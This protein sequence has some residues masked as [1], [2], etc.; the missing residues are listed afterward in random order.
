MTAQWAIDR[1]AAGTM[2]LLTPQSSNWH[3]LASDDPFGADPDDEEQR[4]Y[5][6][7]RDYLFTTRANPRSGF[8]QM[9]KTAMHGVWALG[10]AVN[11][12]EESDRG[13]SSPI[14]Y[15]YVPLNENYLGS[16]FEGVIDTNFRVF[17]RSAR[18]CVAKWGNAVSGRV[19][20]MAATPQDRDRLVTI[21]HAVYPRDEKG[22]TGNTNRTSPFAS[23][24]VEVSERHLIGDSGYFEFPFR[25]DHWQRN[26]AGPYCEG[27]IALALAEIKSLNMLAK[28]ELLG[29]Q[30]WVHPP[31]A[32]VDD[33]MGRINLNPRAPNPG[34]LSPTGELLV[35][36]ITTVQRPDF[37]QSILTQRREAIKETL[38]V[39]L[40][41]ILIQNPNMT[42]T[43]AMIRANEKG[44]LLGPVGTSLQTGLSFQIDREIGIIARRGAF[45]PNSPLAPPQQMSGRSIG[46]KFT[47]PLDRIRR[48]PQLQGMTQLLS[49]GAQLEQ[50][51]PGTMDKI[52]ADK[53][54]DEA[55][56]IL[57][58]PRSVMTDDADLAR[59]RAAKAQQA[60]AQ[61]GIATAHA[62]GAAAQQ[63]AAGADALAG[64]PAAAAIL[65]KLAGLPATGAPA[66]P[67]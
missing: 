53:F 55:Q 23:S 41:Q 47:S 46:V 64:S 32:T 62:A 59:M 11:Y 8:W 18:Q 60:N 63:G 51:K 1:G 26:N 33:G 3:D 52:D 40:W 54:M 19:K 38:Y 31:L 25:V 45:A 57:G 42:A 48:M 50:L 16:N 13:V 9:Q 58:A 61:Q 6:K 37:V 39:N 36:P 49:L 14:S 17:V 2:A 66:L 67:A 15:R 27:P 7:L 4:F 28:Q 65:G 30:Q 24:Y 56:D 20:T 43:E 21:L 5:E 34:W 10:M 12:I 35:K 44:D 29:V 22:A